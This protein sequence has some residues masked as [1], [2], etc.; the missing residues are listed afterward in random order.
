MCICLQ[1]KELKAEN[2]ELKDGIVKRDVEVQHL[3]DKVCWCVV[4]LHV[5]NRCI[6]LC[7][8]YSLFAMRVYSVMKPPN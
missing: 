4:H 7:L 3:K 5:N 6:G 8:K 2:D 1:G